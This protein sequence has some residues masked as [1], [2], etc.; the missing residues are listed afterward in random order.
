M[1]SCPR[2]RPR[3]SKAVA[4]SIV[5][6][7]PGGTWSRCHSRAG[8]RR[9]TK[10]SGTSTRDVMVDPPEGACWLDGVIAGP[11]GKV[12]V[13]LSVDILV[14]CPVGVE[15]DDVAEDPPWTR[16]RATRWQLVERL[17]CHQVRVRPSGR[18]WITAHPVPGRDAACPRVDRSAAVLACLRRPL[19]MC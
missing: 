14:D 2:P 4:R 18:R 11:S 17:L 5:T 13:H 8:L 3:G 16:W 6:C 12:R 19:R 15:E 1:M 7:G 9:C 10:T